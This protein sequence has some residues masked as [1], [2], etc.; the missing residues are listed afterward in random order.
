MGQAVIVEIDRDLFLLLA[1]HGHAPHAGD[2]AQAALQ[3]IHVFAQFTVGLVV[4]F[5][6]NQHRR[7]VAEVVVDLHGEHALRQTGLEHLDAVLELGPESVLVLHV[8]VQ[9]HLDDGD[10]VAA[11]GL[12]FLLFHIFIGEDVV[13]ER[14]GHLL[15]DLLGRSAGIDRHDNALADGDGRELVLVDVI[16]PVDAHRDEDARHHDDDPAVAHGPGHGTEFALV[17]HSLTLLPAFRWIP[18]AVLPQ[19]PC[20]L[21]SGPP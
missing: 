19:S 2:G 10:T 1:H 11:V 13:L 6:G 14:F 17:C 16:Q 12:G 18:S 4:G 9:F 7:R 5:H 20:H 8:V 3:V 21:C 15:L